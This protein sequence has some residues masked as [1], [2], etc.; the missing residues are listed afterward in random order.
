MSA[1]LF[2][3]LAAVANAG[4]ALISKELTQRAPARQLIGVLYARQRPRPAALRAVRAWAWSPTIVA[5]HLVSVAIMVLTAV[6]V[7]DLL[8]AGAASAMTTATGD[9]SDPGGA[10]RLLVLPGA[11]EPAQV[12]A[13]P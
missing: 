7:W 9:E 12:I 11:I 5:L 8:D 10:G 13:A 6:C 2:G 1:V 4:Q 3:L